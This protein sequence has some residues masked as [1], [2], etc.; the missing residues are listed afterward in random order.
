MDK[1]I[2]KSV[3]DKFPEVIDEGESKMSLEMLASKNESILPIEQKGVAYS[4][5]LSEVYSKD[6]ANE[7]INKL[8]DAGAK[9]SETHK[10][11]T[12]EDKSP[13]SESSERVN[14]KDFNT[15]NESASKE[16]EQ[17]V[18]HSLLLNNNTDEGN[19]LKQAMKQSRVIEENQAVVR[20]ITENVISLNK[21]E[22]DYS[23]PY[24]DRLVLLRKY[25]NSIINEIKRV[26][27]IISSKEKSYVLNLLENECTYVT[28]LLKELMPYIALGTTSSS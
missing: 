26:Q 25:T 13:E 4:S 18:C 23:G 15:H 20:L 19:I 3:G 27:N 9:V 2:K 11:I 8:D 16:E 28:K 17:L 7:A 1:G 21:E 12:S 14:V 10:A 22:T 6:H 5:N 24:R